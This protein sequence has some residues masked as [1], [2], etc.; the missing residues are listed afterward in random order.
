MEDAIN[1][2]LV[3]TMNRAKGTKFSRE[4][5]SADCRSR[6]RDEEISSNRYMCNPL[7]AC[8]QSYRGVVLHRTLRYDY[9]IERVPSRTAKSARQFGPISILL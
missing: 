9:Q 1:N 4:S 5:F 8:H 3:E 7:G 2:G 6:A